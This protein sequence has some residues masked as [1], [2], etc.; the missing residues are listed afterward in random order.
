MFNNLIFLWQIIEMDDIHESK[1]ILIFKNYQVLEILFG[2]ASIALTQWILSQDPANFN[3]YGFDPKDALWAL[4][5]IYGTASIQVISA[6][7]EVILSN[8]PKNAIVYQGFGLILIVMQISYLGRYGWEVQHLIASILAL[9]VP[10]FY[11]YGACL[12]KR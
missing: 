7:T 3:V 2:L 9:L 12:D 6:L 5:L 4:L 11:Y 10:C 8:K 1:R